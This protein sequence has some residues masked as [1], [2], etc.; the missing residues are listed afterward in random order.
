MSTWPWL[1][2]KEYTASLLVVWGMFLQFLHLQLGL[3]VSPDEK[4]AQYFFWQFDLVQKHPL[5]FDMLFYRISNSCGL[6]KLFWQSRQLQ[7]RPQ[8]NPAL[9]QSQ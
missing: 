9:K 3:Q 2:S 7:S 1:S 6:S 5:S 8:I 4:Q